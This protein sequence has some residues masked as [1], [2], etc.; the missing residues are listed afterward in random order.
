MKQSRYLNSSVTQIFSNT[1]GKAVAL[2]P[3][4]SMVPTLDTEDYILCGLP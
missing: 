4:L 2:L 1:S 3:G